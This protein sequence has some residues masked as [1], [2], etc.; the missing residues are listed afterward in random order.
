M[1]LFF[2]CLQTAKNVLFFTCPYQSCMLETP[3]IEV[4]L[5]VTSR[6]AMDKTMD[7]I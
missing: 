2:V 7:T 5:L 3:K 1:M 6:L 4:L